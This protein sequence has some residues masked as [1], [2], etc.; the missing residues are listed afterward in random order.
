MV[1][2]IEIGS[3]FWK[4]DVREGGQIY[5]FGH[6]YRYFLAGRTAIDHIIKDIKMTKSLRTV[7]MPSYCCQSMIKPFLDNKIEVEFYSIGF[8]NGCYT[9]D[10]DFD[11]ECDAIL[12]MQY[13]GY[14]NEA[15]DEI[16]ER[17]RFNHKVVIE[18][19]THS[20]FS[21]NQYSKDVD[22]VFMSFRKWTGVVCGAVAI[23]Q[24]DDFSISIPAQTNLSYL[25]KRKEARELKRLFIEEGI[26]KKD[27]FLKR[28]KEAEDFL[29]CDYMNYN[30]PEEDINSILNLDRPEII[31][32]RKANAMF[33]ID[34]ISDIKDIETIRIS[35]ED[36]PLFVPILVKNG[37]RNELQNYLSKNDVYCP[38]HWPVSVNLKICKDFVYLSSLSL[39][40]DQ[41]Y[42][43]DDM[44]YIARLIKE[45]FEK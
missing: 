38:I 1:K 11:K 3:E 5:N 28:F 30:V 27:E 23:K 37:Y 14:K 17:F 19:A 13:F 15:V 44:R 10:I 25:A 36:T 39:V 9:Y 16:I 33:L 7:Y 6:N 24:K 21:T 12:I 42:T 4:A 8:Q 40:C 45:F 20:W 43:I 35:N 32:R 18:D 31:K 22:Y 41:R 34:S 26:G 29:N 2:Q